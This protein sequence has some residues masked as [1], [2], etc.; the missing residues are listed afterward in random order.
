MAE[1]PLTRTRAA[2]CDL[3]ESLSDAQW[4]A[5]S[6]CEGWDAGD[7][8]AHLVARERDL[9][10]SLGILIP[11]LEGL[12]ERSMARR[13]DEGRAA[14][15]AD[16]RRGPSPWMRL[17]IAR[18]VQ[19]GEDWIHTADIARGGAATA[20]GPSLPISD[21]TEDPALA[22]LLWGAVGRFAPMTLR[23][24]AGQGVV[25]LTDGSRHRTYRVGGAVAR[26]ARGAAADVT[27]RGPV[28]ELVLFATGRRGAEVEVD[29]D[30]RLAAALE[31]ADRGF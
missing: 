27:V 23:G 25:D 16:L 24:V 29:G 3:L 6:L 18:D 4:Q 9:V 17:P 15:I 28:G 13:K 7:V 31:A 8:A 14:L 1:H 10:S 5:E 19:V 26:P 30:G 2:L 12:H 20:E 22:E 21:G 11:P